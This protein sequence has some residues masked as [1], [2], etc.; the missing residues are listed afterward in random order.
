MELKQNASRCA[1]VLHEIYGI[2]DHIHDYAN[3]L[4][5]EK[6]DVYVP[7]LLQSNTSFSYNEEDIA[8]HY[9]SENI[10]FEKAHGQVTALINDLSKTYN[11]IHLIGFSIG[12]T[13][14]WLCSN[15]KDVHKVVGFYGSRIRQYTALQPLADVTLIYGKQEKSFV[16]EDL[17]RSLSI[18][19]NVDFKIVD[20]EHGFADP[21]S[22][23][24]NKDVTKRL[25]PLLLGQ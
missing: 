7:N 3:L 9:F 11:E 4:F 5:K 15:H 18:Y 23:K 21:Y 14:A 8:Y 20:G 1:I 24:Y 12:A 17:Q 13:V 6:F 2:N 10:G 16:P 22:V 19:P 25:L